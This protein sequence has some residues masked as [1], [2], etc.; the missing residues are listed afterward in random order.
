L[1]KRVRSVR[2][3][4]QRR[5]VEFAALTMHPETDEQKTRKKQK[6]ALTWEQR[7][8]HL[9]ESIEQLE[10]ELS[11]LQEQRAKTPHHLD[12]DALP[13]DDQFDRLAP[14]RKRLMDTVKLVSYRTETVLVNIVREELARD[15]DARS[16]IRD[17]FRSEANLLVDRAANQLTVEVH[18]LSNARSNRAIAHLLTHLN[19]AD[20]SYPGTNLKLVYTLLSTK[21]QPT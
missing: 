1:D 13:A 18:S 4:L 15:D 5:Q 20:L 9:V 19:A 14:S 12:W 17:L 6:D 21:T 11:E 2:G 10:H 16:L 3:K 7:K 8:S